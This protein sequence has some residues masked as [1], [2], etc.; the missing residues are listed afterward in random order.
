MIDRWKVVAMYATAKSKLER[1]PGEQV[2][3][4]VNPSGKEV[5]WGSR[6]LPIQDFLAVVRSGFGK[7][8]EFEEVVGFSAGE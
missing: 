6:E 1:E 3:E 5:S 8:H 2:G 4:S 7:S